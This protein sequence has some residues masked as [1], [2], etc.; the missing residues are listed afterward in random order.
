MSAERGTRLHLTEAQLGVWFGQQVDPTNPIFNVGGYVE[1]HGAVAE[2]LVEAAVRR[3]VAEADSLRTR[4]LTEGEEHWQFVLPSV[5]WT[6]PRH[7]FRAEADP[8]Q[9]AEAWM[10][11]ALGRAMDPGSAPLFAFALLAVAPDRH[12]V[13]QCYHHLVADSYTIGLLSRRI[14]EAY[15]ALEAGEPVGRVRSHR[16]GNWWSA[17]A[18][19]AVRRAARKTGGSG[20]TGSTAGP[21]RSA[22][23]GGR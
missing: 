2:D 21:S 13:F 9:A 4:F 18:S 3:T 22:C 16:S 11:E 15:T 20:W 23:P 19:T 17:T 1:I 5:D 7:D 6:M 10:R 8:W 14:A 12:L